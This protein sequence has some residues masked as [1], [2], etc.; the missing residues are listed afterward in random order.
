[1]PDVPATEARAGP[2]FG[3]LMD[4]QARIL[5]LSGVTLAAILVTRVV[6]S[7]FKGG[8]IP[9][10]FDRGDIGFGWDTPAIVEFT[11]PYCYECKEVLPLLKAAS[12][13]YNMPLKVIDAKERPD[14]ASKYAVRST[15]T[16][17]VVDKSGKVTKGWVSS[18]DEA[19][20]SQAIETAALQPAF[21]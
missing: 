12:K 16:I 5:I 18:P 9:S 17:L 2:G 3:F 20:L 10:T 1:M 8:S 7:Y 14:L 13:V 4:L 11:S 15:P 21:G 19:E 6:V